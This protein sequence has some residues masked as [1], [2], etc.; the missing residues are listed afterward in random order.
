MVFHTSHIVN[1]PRIRAFI[2]CPGG[3]HTAASDRDRLIGKGTA[4]ST[5]AGAMLFAPALLD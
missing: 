3:N 5:G 1:V 4:V 2:G